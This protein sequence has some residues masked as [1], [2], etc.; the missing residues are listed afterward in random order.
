MRF[1]IRLKLS[2]LW[3]CFQA[4]LL[5]KT[6]EKRKTKTSKSYKSAVINNV[7]LP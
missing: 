6:K 1:T 5:L 2:N 7:F 4:T 3:L